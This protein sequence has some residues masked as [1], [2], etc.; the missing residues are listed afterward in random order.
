MDDLTK[1]VNEAMAE[2][3]KKPNA[4]P[5]APADASKSRR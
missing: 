2:R 4:E 1:A 3:G 5:N